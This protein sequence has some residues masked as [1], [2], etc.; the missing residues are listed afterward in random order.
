MLMQQLGLTPGRQV[1]Q[2]L[3][4]LM[5]AQAAGITTKEEAIK[6]AS[7]WLHEPESVV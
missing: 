5:E 1:G 7:S 4:R 2:L 6:L 3:E